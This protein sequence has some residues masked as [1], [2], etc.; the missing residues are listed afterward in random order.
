M[1]GVF[2]PLDRHAVCLH[3]AIVYLL[4][5]VF[6]CAC[7]AFGFY[8]LWKNMK[9]TSHHIWNDPFT[10]TTLHRIR[11][12]SPQRQKW[13][14]RKVFTTANFS[15]SQFFHALG[16][17]SSHL[18]PSWDLVLLP[19]YVTTKISSSQ[20][21]YPLTEEFS[22]MCDLVLL[23]TYVIFW[24]CHGPGTANCV[25][26]CQNFIL[27]DFSSSHRRVFSDVWP[28]TTSYIC[29]F[30]M[31][32]WMFDLGRASPP[33]QKYLRHGERVLLTVY[34]FHPLRFFILSQKSFQRCVTCYY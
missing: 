14:R 15:S 22:A 5:L 8:A 20:I 30:L 17:K 16:D 4:M 34:V 28:G 12:P 6:L 23:A 26:Y 21:F 9:G 25:R 1:R 10:D 11:Y 32:S 13:S 18:F 29:Y 33:T 3:L 7:V 2:P 24:S 27:S 31:M 19:V